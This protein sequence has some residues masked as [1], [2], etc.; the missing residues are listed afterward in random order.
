[1]IRRC[2]MTL[3]NQPINSTQKPKSYQNQTPYVSFFAI[4][5]GTINQIQNFPNFPRD[6]SVIYFSH[7]DIF[8]V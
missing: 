2:R 1:M 5:F 6:L 4:I 7:S 8:L 3:N